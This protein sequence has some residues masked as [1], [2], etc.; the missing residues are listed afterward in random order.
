MYSPRPMTAATKVMK[1][2]VPYQIKKIT[3]RF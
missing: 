3:D 2:D 1:D